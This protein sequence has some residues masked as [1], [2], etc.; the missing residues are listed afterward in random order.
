MYKQYK[1]ET[2]QGVITKAEFLDVVRQ[3]GITDVFLQD[4]L[5]R[6]CCLSVS[7]SIT[8]PAERSPSPHLPLTHATRNPPRNWPPL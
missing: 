7:Q 1:K 5:F 4:L 2:P 8:S 6:V 3:M